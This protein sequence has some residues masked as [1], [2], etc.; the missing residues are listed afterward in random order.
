MRTE[1]D[2][3]EPMGESFWGRFP[4]LILLFGLGM[5]VSGVAGLFEGIVSQLSVIV[6]FQSLVL[7]MAGNVGTQSLAVTIRALAREQLTPREMRRLV[8]RESRLGLCNGLLLGGL[9]FLF[10]GAYL[11]WI[12]GLEGA[13]AFSVSLCTGLALFFSMVLSGMAG[14]V[15]PLLCK[16]LRIDPAVAS[17]PFITTLNDLVAVVAYYGLSWLILI[18]WRGI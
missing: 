12:R 5:L 4:W 14:S 3:D 2:W 6:S 1:E 10:I 8:L 15:I 13:V 11:H 9:S 7:G 18:R 17:G 16:K